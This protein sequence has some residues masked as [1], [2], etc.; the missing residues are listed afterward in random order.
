MK[1]I[2]L[3]KLSFSNLFRQ[4]MRTFLTVI[5]IVIG[6]TLISLVYSIIPGFENFLNV[7]L[8]T[9]NSK[10]V[11]DVTAS[12][13]RPGADL[14]SSLTGGPQEYK[15]GEETSSVDFEFEAF[16]D[17]DIENMK[18]IGGVKDVYESP[19]PSVEYLR[20]ENQDKRFKTS[21][22]F[23]YPKFLL[24]NLNIVS[25]RKIEDDEEGK[26]LLSYDYIEAF[27]YENPDDLIGKKVILHSKQTLEQSM[28]MSPLSE[29]V[30]QEEKDFE[31]EI[32]G[33]AEKNILSSVIFISFKDAVE[34][35]KFSKG[36]EEVL[37]DNDEARF[38]AWVELE[39]EELADE[40]KAEIEELGF[41]ARTYEDS[42][43]VLN[44]IFDVLTVT[45]SSFGILAMAVSSLGII[46]TLIMAV[47]ERTREIGVLKAIGATR[48][49]IASLFTIE[50]SMIGVIGGIIG[51]GIGFG[52]SEIIDIWGHKT[53]LS[54]FE[55]LDLSNVSPL[56]LLG[57]VLSTVIATIAGIYPALRAS[58][59]NP[60][61]ALRYE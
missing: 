58:K 23:F 56:L 26:I 32:V 30:E 28:S 1:L 3:I 51:L 57:P 47:Y 16:T 48:F 59:L 13:N 41:R 35:T 44:D 9:L 52:I 34:I 10:K 11:I 12:S 8:N 55:T 46:N 2:D 21:F 53:I 27:G 25:G 31:L 43:D 18:N 5:S 54:T 45:F 49:N 24:E 33:I 14:L 42:K 61:E 37:T 36:T 17:E 20:L 40:V 60:V 7:Q 29:E 6:A 15:D 38:S 39:S 50:A 4:K 19:T 22:V